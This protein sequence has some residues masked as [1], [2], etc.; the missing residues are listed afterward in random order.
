MNSGSWELN[1]SKV[2]HQP[3]EHSTPPPK[4]VPNNYN[5]EAQQI[6]NNKQGTT[7][8]KHT[9]DGYPFWYM[10]ECVWSKGEFYRCRAL[11]GGNLFS[12]PLIY[13]HPRA[14]ALNIAPSSPP[15]AKSPRVGWMLW[16]VARMIPFL[17]PHSMCGSSAVW[18]SKSRLL[19]FIFIPACSFFV[20]LLMGRQPHSSI[21][22][23]KLW[24]SCQKKYFKSLAYPENPI[25][26]HI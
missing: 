1:C 10:S 5:T 7:Y 22:A 19:N 24:V 3:P 15:L 18:P 17:G 12:G 6:T 25:V 14:N 11:F 26:A 23:K 2:R 21:K 16:P 20:A 9:F 13:W 4:S 8:T